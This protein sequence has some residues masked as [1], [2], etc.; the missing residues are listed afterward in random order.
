VDHR[1]PHRRDGPLSS[2][3]VSTGAADVVAGAVLGVIGTGS[4]H[5]ALLVLCV[6]TMV[7]GQFISN[8]ATVLVV[9][10]I[11]VAISQSLEVSVQPFMMALTVAGPRHS[12]PRS[13]RP[14]TSW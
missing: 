4:P 3:F 13:R 8:V 14:R 2:A 6:L 9:I 7:L 12:S 11:A 5:L 1:H 10:P